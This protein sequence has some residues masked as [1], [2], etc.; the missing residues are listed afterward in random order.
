MSTISLYKKLQ[1]TA[2]YPELK[3]VSTAIAIAGFFF[4]L[5]NY[6]NQALAFLFSETG[7]VCSTFFF[8]AIAVAYC[9]KIYYRIMVIKYH[10]KD[11]RIRLFEN[12]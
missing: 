4:L 7:L 8:V 5:Y 1:R 3:Q 9:I 6:G 12:I 10:E 11:T 2:Y